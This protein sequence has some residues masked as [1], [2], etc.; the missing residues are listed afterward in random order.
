M[1]TDLPLDQLHHRALVN[2]GGA[3]ISATV[4]IATVNEVV[5]ITTGILAGACSLAAAVYYVILIIEKL[6]RK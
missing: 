1:L 3:A 6:R 5:Q 4:S 2:V